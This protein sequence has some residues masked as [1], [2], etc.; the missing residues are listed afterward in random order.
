[1]WVTVGRVVCGVVGPIP[2][3]AND[4]SGVGSPGVTVGNLGVG[5]ADSVALSGAEVGSG[6]GSP[7]VTVGLLVNLGVGSVDL[8]V[9]AGEEVGSGVG[10]SGVTVRRPVSVALTREPF[11]R[12]V[13]V[14]SADDG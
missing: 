1:V 12:P 3:G 6:V 11:G 9:L 4:G 14:V 13:S 7:G 10:S 2:A 5:L 8:V